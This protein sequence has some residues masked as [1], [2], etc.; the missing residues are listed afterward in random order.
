MA[1]RVF[2]GQSSMNA[3]I[4]KRFPASIDYFRAPFLD[5]ERK[6]SPVLPTI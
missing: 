1:H 5:F 2:N 4:F 6:D 3:L